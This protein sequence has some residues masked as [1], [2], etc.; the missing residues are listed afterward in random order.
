MLKKISA[1]LLVFVIISISSVNVFAGKTG[2]TPGSDGSPAGS[3]KTVVTGGTDN[4]AGNTT[5]ATGNTAGTPD[6]TADAAAGATGDNANAGKKA[7]SDKD[8]VSGQAAEQNKAAAEEKKPNLD[9]IIKELMGKGKAIN[10]D[11]GIIEITSPEEDKEST[12][13]EA[14]VL[15]GNT[16]YSDVVVHIARYNEETGGYEWIKNTDGESS[17][18]IGSIRIFTKEITLNKGANEIMIISYRLSQK[19][20]AKADNVQFNC[21]TVEKLDKSI[22][23]GI[24]KI[25]KEAASNISEG[26]KSFMEI[27]GKKQD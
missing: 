22:K 1:I 27:I 3:G 18:E 20:E 7:G 4:T 2:N 9:D 11:L 19:E 15:S 21:F 17:W 8:A 13:Y 16:E 14:Y 26:F 10:N 12:Y 6:G 25:T 24:I 23:D 5:Q